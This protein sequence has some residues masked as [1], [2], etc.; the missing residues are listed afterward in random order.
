[1]GGCAG[2]D[3]PD[4]AST[5]LLEGICSCQPGKM[6]AGVVKVRPSFM[7]CPRFNSTI[8]LAT[9]P[10]SEPS[11]TRSAMAQTLS[12][13]RTVTVEFRPACAAVFTVCA[14]MS[15]EAGTWSEAEAEA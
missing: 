11:A 14:A 15:R 2:I 1:M 4:V 13:G 5:R 10:I 9:L 12:P 8:W 3:V 6:S 7:T